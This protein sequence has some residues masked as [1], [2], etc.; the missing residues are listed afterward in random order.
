MKVSNSS[1]V[2]MPMSVLIEPINGLLLAHALVEQYRLQEPF[3]GWIASL[4]R[5][6]S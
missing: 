5:F 1:I 6:G 4:N 3:I 2:V